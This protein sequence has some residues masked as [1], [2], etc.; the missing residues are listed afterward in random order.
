MNSL[1]KPNWRPRGTYCSFVVTRAAAAALAVGGAVA[2]TWFAAAVPPSGGPLP[3]G[4]V[5]GAPPGL[6]IAFDEPV[7]DFGKVVVGEVLHHT[8]AFTNL[9]AEPLELK[10]VRSSCGC[11]ASAGWSK[12]VEPGQSGIIPIELHTAGLNGAVSK[13][14]TVRFVDTNKPNAT[15]QVKA[16]VWHPLK[17]TPASAGL[18]VVGGNVSNV[19]SVVRIVNNEEGPVTLSE[20][21]SDQPAIAAELKTIEP[22]RTFELLVKPVA[23]LGSG[24]VFGK[25]NLRTSSTNMP[26]L[27]I[28]AWILNQAPVVVVPPQ[29]LVPEGR[30]TN[31][32]TRDV[33]I[34]GYGTN[35][36]TLSQ[37]LLDL[38]GV[39]GQ[40]I[41]LQTGRVYTVR[42]AF[43]KGFEL[44]PGRDGELRLQSNHPQ[45]PIIRVPIVHKPPPTPAA[46][47]RPS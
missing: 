16:N 45:F 15:L 21:E 17:A 4:T 27:T 29:I 30:S 40:L 6:K 13:P 37:P 12:R 9:D 47:A 38:E 34:R 22:G 35:A 18:R 42:L 39:E 33:S 25:I 26:V 41:E 32:F 14:V 8:F 28:S 23:P 2:G 43:P 11:T 46:P 7:H 5:L 1:G 20:P 10:E 24:N 31:A 44:P 36:L 3:A 19:V